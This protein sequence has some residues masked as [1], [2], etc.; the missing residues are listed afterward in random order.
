MDAIRH[1]SCL[2]ISDVAARSVRLFW[3]LTSANK[4]L[5][6]RTELLNETVPRAMTLRAP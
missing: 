2:H 1:L 5:L 3:S 6:T 4:E